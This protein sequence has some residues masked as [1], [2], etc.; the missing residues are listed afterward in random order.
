VIEKF[1]IKKIIK[2]NS[3]VNNI[4][5]EMLIFVSIDAIIFNSQQ[6]F[7]FKVK[8]KNFIFFTFNCAI[9]GVIEALLEISIKNI[10]ALREL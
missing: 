2:I 8:G 3:K 6:Y 4:L 10:F 1:I 5:K 7:Q 9:H